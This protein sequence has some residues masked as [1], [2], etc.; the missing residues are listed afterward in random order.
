VRPAMYF[1]DNATVITFWASALILFMALF[2]FYSSIQ[3]YISRHLQEIQ[4]NN[5]TVITQLNATRSS[6][7]MTFYKIIDP[8]I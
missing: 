3:S 7:M 1:L 6:A 4:Q 5:A 2:S 8:I